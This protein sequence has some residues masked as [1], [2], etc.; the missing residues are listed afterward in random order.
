MLDLTFRLSEIEALSPCANWIE[1]VPSFSNVADYPS[2]QAG[3]EILKL[4]G[5]HRVEAFPQDEEF[6]RFIRGK[7]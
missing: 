3:H 5:A 2:R 4:V 7:A 6:I 1:R